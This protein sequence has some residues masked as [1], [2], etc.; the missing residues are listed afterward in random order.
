MTLEKTSYIIQ[1]KYLRMRGGSFL[2]H[3]QS[4]HNIGDPTG[5][6]NPN[7][8]LRYSHVR[9]PFTMAKIVQPVR[10]FVT[11]YNSHDSCLIQDFVSCI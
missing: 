5:T 4:I 8:D 2:D 3:L 9:L 11:T 6:V 1:K 10:K 7:S